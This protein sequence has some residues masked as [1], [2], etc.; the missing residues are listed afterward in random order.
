MPSLINKT[1]LVTGATRGIG[2]AIARM[3][4]AEGARVAIC[5]RTEAATAQAAAELTAETS[6]KVVG[7]AADVSQYTEVVKLF[8]WLEDE[9]GPLDVLVNNAGIGIFGAVGELSL[10]Q[11][12][13]T[14]DTNL[15][16]PFYCLRQ[17][18]PGME[19]K[20]GGHIVN[21]GSMAGA[22]AFPGGAAYN[23]S[24]FGLTGFTD[25]S[26]QDL[27]K[28]NIRVTYVMPG[29]T[30]T[31]FGGGEPQAGADWK[32]WPEDIAEVVKTVLQMPE[33]TLVSRIEVR[34]ARPKS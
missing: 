5:G 18:L 14:L 13:R 29:S 1:C 4:A 12:K 9:L 33:R 21:I 3:L 23:A 10:E 26:M 31:H 19:A 15:S 17:A 32:I 24:K 25:A 7:K 11:W 6:S 30:A 27:R 20:G 28:K 16:G 34:P 8:E 2:R 22:Y